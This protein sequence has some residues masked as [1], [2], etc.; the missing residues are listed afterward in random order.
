M[1]AIAG[2]RRQTRSGSVAAILVLAALAAGCGSS[3]QGEGRSQT[4]PNIKRIADLQVTSKDIHRAGPNSPGGALLHWWQALQLGE[5]ATARDAYASSADTTHLYNEVK[6]LE[7]YIIRSHPE[8]V[9][10]KARG[11]RA[12]LHTTIDE[13]TFREGNPNELLV[14][15]QTLTS[16]RLVRENGDW[17]LANNHYLAQLFREKTG[18]NP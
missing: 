7:Y 1:P 12:R 4:R 18:R 6:H 14:V 10:G 5:I 16:F 11:G 17:K 9:E 13:A 2:S 15:F 3:A 8:I